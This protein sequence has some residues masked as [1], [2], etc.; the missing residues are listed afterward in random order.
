MAVAAS[1]MALALGRGVRSPKTGVE[2]ATT[3]T[4]R[5]STASPPD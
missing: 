1:G 2:L 3:L 5:A 4:I